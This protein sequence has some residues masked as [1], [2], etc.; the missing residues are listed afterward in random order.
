MR[1]TRESGPKKKKQ[2]KEGKKHHHDHIPSYL[3]EEMGNGHG[4]AELFQK[5]AKE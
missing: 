4:L 2:A 1:L 5:K 3:K